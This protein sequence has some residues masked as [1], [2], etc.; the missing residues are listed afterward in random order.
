M[1]VLIVGGGGREHTLAWKLAQSDKV[2]MIYAAPGNA[3]I[4][5]ME[6]AEC[7][8]IKDSDIEGLKNFA[9]EKGI[10]L[11]V[12]G[13]EAPLVDGIS[14][15]FEA[16]GL[17]VFG[18]SKEAAILEGSKAF[19]K[20]LMKKYN[21]PTADFG[22]FDDQAAAI[23][24]IKQKGAPIV[25][26]AD[27]LAAGKGVLMAQT[28]EEAIAAVKQVMEEKAFGDA[29]NHVVIEEMLEGE[30]ASILAFV[31][32]E[33]VK[34]MVSSQDHKRALDGDKGLNTGGMGAYSP[35]PI[36]S[37]EMRQKVLDEVMLP[38]V[39][40]MKEEGRLYKGVLYA[41]LM[42]KDGIPK[43]LEFNC[44]FGDPETQV[45]LPRTKSDLFD[46]MVACADGTLNE[47]TLEWDERACTCIVMASGGYPEKYEKGKPISGLEE[48][49]QLPDTVVF[50]AGTKLEDNTVLT[51]G[52]RVLGVTALGEGIKESIDKA[53]AA[54]AKI[55]FEEAH[56]RKDIGF[57]ALNRD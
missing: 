13:P 57:R 14:N 2:E 17:K 26:K 40:A 56:Y 21:I 28:E 34:L 45:V 35:A 30:E 46:V 12:V 27:G 53:Y 31:D 22:V 1:K 9:F 8:A 48:A 39:Q 50:H 43:V 37:E 18:P 5:G 3:G 20:D 36:V 24:Y 47:L 10:D 25:V 6:K 11:T 41:G 51:S 19:S 33:T 29:G 52:G 55:S 23:E 54:L 49:N 42:I 32:G 15:E 4:A 44:P 7:V 38:T 16:N